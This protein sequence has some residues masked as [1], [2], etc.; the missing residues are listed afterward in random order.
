MKSLLSFVFLLVLLGVS[1][2]KRKRCITACEGLDDGQYQ[3]CDTC[4]RFAICSNEVRYE[5]P[6]P[7]GL[8]W[9]DKEKKCVESSTTCEGLDLAGPPKDNRQRSRNRKNKASRV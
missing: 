9:D 3:L 4:S 2:G 7:P 6:C 5:M 1:E 8:A